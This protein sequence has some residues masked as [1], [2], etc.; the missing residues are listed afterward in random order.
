MS[1]ALGFNTLHPAVSMCVCVYTNLM[2]S[3][4]C[5]NIDCLSNDNTHTRNK[6]TANKI[7]SNAHTFHKDLYGEDMKLRKTDLVLILCVYISA[8][9]ICVNKIAMQIHAEI[10]DV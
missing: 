8:K 1:N 2:T 3:S 5:T 4:N 10:V 9:L 7:K 6:I